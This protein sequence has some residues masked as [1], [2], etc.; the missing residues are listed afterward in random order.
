MKSKCVI[1]I[2]EGEKSV[3]TEVKNYGVSIDYATS[4]LEDLLPHLK[5]VN[6]EPTDEEPNNNEDLKAETRRLEKE[7]LDSIKDPV[8]KRITE[9]L[10][11]AIKDAIGIDVSPKE[12]TTNE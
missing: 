2:T 1:T 3:H 9:S 8:K 5:N 4:S 7:L 6:E 11:T 10:L 12:E